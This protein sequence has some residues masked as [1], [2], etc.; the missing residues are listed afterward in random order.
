MSQTTKIPWGPFPDCVLCSDGGMH[1]I[2]GIW[3]FCLCAAG[4][5]RR[6]RE[7]NAVTEANLILEKLGLK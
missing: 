6:E 1:Q 7:P 4:I 5:S 2:E 3:K